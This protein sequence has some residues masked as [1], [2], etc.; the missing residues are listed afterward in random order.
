MDLNQV[1][2]LKLSFQ[3]YEDQENVH[4]EFEYLVVKFATGQFWHLAQPQV[5]CINPW[6]KHL[7][8]CDWHE[9]EVDIQKS[10]DQLSRDQNLWWI[11]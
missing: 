6:L 10:S 8:D 11:S 9:K 5:L 7:D 4:A 3:S 1:L 2:Q